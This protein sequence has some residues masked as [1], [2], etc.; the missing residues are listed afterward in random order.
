MKW[1]LEQTGEGR[2]IP[3][4]NGPWAAVH[5]VPSPGATALS[6]IP[7]QPGTASGSAPRFRPCGIISC[8]V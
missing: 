7:A 3:R 5:P 6:P 1:H 2:P 4:D 8:K